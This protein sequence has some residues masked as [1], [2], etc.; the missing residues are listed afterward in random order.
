MFNNYI[1]VIYAILAAFCYAISTPFSKFFLNYLP[2]TF[3]ASLLY[4]GAGI[5]MFIVKILKRK[6]TERQE[7]NVTKKELPYV[8]MMVVLDIAAPLFLMF[9]LIKTNASTVSLL[10]NFEIV[11]TTTLALI[12]F[13][14]AIGKQMW[15][16]ISL[17]TVSTILLSVDDF[18][19]L[20]FSLGSIL[21]LLACMCWG[22]E[23]NCT[24]KLSLKN[25]LDIVIIKG[26]GSG[27]GA[28]LIA[29]IT[30]QYVLHIKIIIFALFLGFI[31]YGLSVFFYILAQRNLGAAR[32]SAY[33]AFSP[34]IGVALSLIIFKEKP[35]LNFGMAFIVMILG[36]YF[37]ISEKHKHEHIHKLIEHEHRHNHNDGHHEHEHEQTV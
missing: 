24:S 25:P 2:P 34:F 36:T 30:G 35:T 28:L 26:L 17:I 22:L 6:N 33:Y 18:S 19:T 13:K 14:E 32:T 21:V 4:M 7:A 16:A 27:F 12:I 29:I 20:S 37:A 9:G 3:M 31:A 11:A 15:L 10:N 5:G 1:P 23:N 8:L